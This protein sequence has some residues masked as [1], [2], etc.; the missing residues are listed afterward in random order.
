MLRRKL[1]QAENVF[2]VLQLMLDAALQKLAFP[3][4]GPPTIAD[5]GCATGTN[6]VSDS[7]FVVKTLTN[8]SGIGHGGALMAEFQ[9]YFSDLLCNDFNGLFSL[10]DGRGHSRYF[11]A[12]VPVSFYNAVFPRSTIH[13][14]FSVMALHW[15]SQ[16]PQA[17][18]TK[19]SPL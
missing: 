3:K 15:L 10:L 6:T 18:V 16:V 2:Q 19:G 11:V 7:D 4:E 12:G 8:L 17:V 14:C 5:L 9:A 1:R 13:V